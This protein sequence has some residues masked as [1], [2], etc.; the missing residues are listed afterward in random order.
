MIEMQNLTYFVEGNTY[1][2]SCSRPAGEVMRFRVEP[3]KE[4]GQ[5]LAWY[6]HTDLCFE[7]AGEKVQQAFPLTQ[8]GLD[9][10]RGWL[11]TVW[12]SGAQ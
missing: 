6:W 2:G 7:Q 3:D 8:Q 4:S 10:V 5:L 1:T 12:Q 9:Q 11:E